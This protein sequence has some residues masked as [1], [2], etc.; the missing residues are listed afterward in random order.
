MTYTAEQFAELS[1]WEENFRTALGTHTGWT[2][3]VSVP[4]QR[5]IRAIYMEATGD[6]IPFNFGCG[7]CLLNLLKR[8][9][10]RYFDD[11]AAREELAKAEQAKQAESPI[12]EPEFDP[13]PAEPA[14]KATRSRVKV[15][16]TDAKPKAKKSSTKKAKAPKTE[17]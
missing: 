6:R 7:T 4:D 14:K 15:A 1:K 9:G 10:K 3:R 13:A 11:K 16:E 2:K 5:R 8:A 17:K 12:P